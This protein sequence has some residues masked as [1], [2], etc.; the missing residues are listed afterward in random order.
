VPRD[1][2]VAV[3]KVD[4]ATPAQVL[5]QLA[6]AGELAFSAY[7]PVA[8]R[9]REGVAD[10]VEEVVARLP[11]GPRYF[12]E[13]V[14][15]D[16]PEAFWVAELVRE[17]LLALTHDEVPHSVTCR[18]TE[19]DWPYVRCEILVERTSQRGIVIGKGGSVLKQVGTAVRQQIPP[20]AYLDLV[21]KVERDWQRRPTA[22]DGLGY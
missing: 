20:G 13:G 12:P 21:V 8:A 11:P 5:D 16:A 15:T 6:R 9:T 19:W 17:Q 18:V 4:A 7:F 22:L 14:V 3:N 1:A 10:L 2:I